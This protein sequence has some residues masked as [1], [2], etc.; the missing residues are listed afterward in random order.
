[1]NRPLHIWL[2]FACC[3]V[4]ALLAMGWVSMTLLRLEHA[5][6]QSQAQAQREENVRLALWRMD[7]ALAPL[8]AQESGRPYFSFGSFYPAERA[9]T[10]MFAEVQR[11][12]VLIPSP[13]LT[14]PAPQTIVHFQFDPQGVLTSPQVPLGNKRNLAATVCVVDNKVDGAFTKLTEFSQLVQRDALLKLIPPELPAAEPVTVTAWNDSNTNYANGNNDND[15]YGSDSKQQKRSIAESK[16]RQR[17]YQSINTNAAWNANNIQQ[18]AQ[19]QGQFFNGGQLGNALGFNNSLAVPP[20]SNVTEGVI[21]PVWLGPALVLARRVNV[22]G[23]I[24]IQ[25]CWLDW[26]A[27]RTSL[28]AGVADLL[29]RADLEPV[30]TDPGERTPYMLAALPVALAPGLIPVELSTATSPI[31]LTLYV[32]WA[33]VI[34]AAA[35][36]ALLLAGAISL[37]ERRGAFVSAV[38]HELRTP[39]TTFRMYTEM[40]AGGMVPD[41]A[42]RLSYLNTLRVEA[43]RLSHLVENVLAYA[44]LERG[45]AKNRL[46][47]VALRDLLEHARGRLADR[48]SQ[49]GMNIVIEGRDEQFALQVRTDSS[50]V[51]QILFN[52]V[53]NACKYASSSSD[54]T[55]HISAAAVKNSGVLRV[56]D[57]GSGFDRQ[58]LRTLFQ[59]F[60]K[61][62]TDAAHSAPGVGLGLALSRRL[63]RDMG[64]DLKLDQN[65]KD[66]ACFELSMPLQ[67]L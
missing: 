57:H 5:E 12:E 25:G 29:P 10:R 48:A 41:E 35:A 42:K 31:R 24:Y 43:E 64:G 44:R 2:A 51:E 20:F 15:S 56:R 14:H 67:A 8:I 60:S 52:L 32:A 50:A 54:M 61:S 65:I 63:A 22:N 1:M 36:V 59:P 37:S 53:D 58:S 4:I 66:G 38:T 19:G 26:P 23:Q 18:E 21:K 46:Q 30:R 33:A 27:I 40:L 13:L 16:N 34:L 17:A 11:G 28:L 62:A 3:L 7:S 55:I 9:Y 45:P 6:E 47:T 49:C 39:L